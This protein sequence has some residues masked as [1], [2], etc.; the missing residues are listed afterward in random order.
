MFKKILKADSL[1]KMAKF[2][3]SRNLT[4]IQMV[5]PVSQQHIISQNTARIQ[6]SFAQ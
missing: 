1:N 6:A 3:T 2:Q 5:K 4:N